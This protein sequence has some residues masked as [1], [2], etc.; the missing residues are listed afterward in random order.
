MTERI[1][2]EDEPEV[3]KNR[4]LKIGAKNSSFKAKLLEQEK[5]ERAKEEFEKRADEF[6]SDKQQKQLKV[7]KTANDFMQAMRD[8]TVLKNKGVVLISS[9]L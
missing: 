5:K 2:F 1:A 4:E 3:K 8:K 7:V 6:I 9:N